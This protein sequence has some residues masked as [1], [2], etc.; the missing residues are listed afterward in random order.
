MAC[1]ADQIIESEATF[2]GT[3]KALDHPKL[4]GVIKKINECRNLF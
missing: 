2:A 3:T 4:F 1:R